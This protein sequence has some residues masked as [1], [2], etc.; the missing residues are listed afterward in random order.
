MLEKHRKEE[1]I[2]KDKT[3]TE[4]TGGSLVNQVPPDVYSLLG[5]EPS[6][7]MKPADEEQTSV[8]FISDEIRCIQDGV[9]VDCVAFIA[10]AKR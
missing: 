6:A 9:A 4:R 2:A 7:G 5:K 8:A 3:G 1:N 10:E